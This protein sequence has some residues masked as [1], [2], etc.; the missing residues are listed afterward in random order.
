MMEVKGKERLA[1]MHDPLH[2]ICRRLT[3]VPRAFPHANL[4]STDVSSLIFHRSF[5][6]DL[7]MHS[8][9]ADA[10]A[11]ISCTLPRTTNVFR[12]PSTQRATVCLCICLWLLFTLYLPEARDRIARIAPSEAR[13]RVADLH[14]RARGAPVRGHRRAVRVRVCLEVEAGEAPLARAPDE[15]ERNRA[16]AAECEECGEPKREA[17]CRAVG[18][19]LGGGEVGHGGRRRRS[20]AGEI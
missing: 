9:S 20:L 16:A 17:D 2:C 18:E 11:L 8:C 4:W 5:S 1:H 3:S 7:G 10:R 19:A 6:W 14:R 12:N 13:N 15:H